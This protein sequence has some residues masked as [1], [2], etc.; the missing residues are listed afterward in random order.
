[1][2][3]PKWMRSR[4]FKWVCLIA[5]L[6]IFY[7]VGLVPALSACIFPEKCRLIGEYEPR[8][9]NPE[10]STSKAQPLKLNL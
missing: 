2:K 1:M 8:T 4:L 6:L 7:T 3:F 9:P 5:A 10:R